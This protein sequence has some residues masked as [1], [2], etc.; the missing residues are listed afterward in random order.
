MKILLLLRRKA[1][2]SMNHKVQIKIHM[3]IYNKK[4]VSI[5][6]ITLTK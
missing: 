2:E 3:C 1:Y 6:Y 4:V 5:V